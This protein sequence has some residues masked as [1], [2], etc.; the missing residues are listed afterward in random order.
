MAGLKDYIQTREKDGVDMKKLRSIW[1]FDLIILLVLISLFGLMMVYSS[2]FTFSILEYGNA[3]HFFNKQLTWIL[4]G[5]VLFMIASFFP[6]KLY[7]KYVAYMVFISII[8]LLL[9]LIPGV[10]VE[11]NFATRW[12]KLGPLLFQPSEIAKLVMIVYFAKV[13]TNKRD[14][15]HDFRHGLMP[16]LIMLGIVFILI[17][18][19]PDLGTALSL[20]VACGAILL[21]SGARW[22]HLTGLLTIAMSGVLILAL[23][24][25]YRMD[26]IISFTNP[27]AD[28]AGEGF[29]LINSYIAISSGGF[30]GVGLGNSVQKLGY[31]P[32]AHTDFIMAIIVEELGVFGVIAVMG[33]YV[34]LLLKGFS[35][36]KKTPDYFAKLL[37]FGLIILISFQAVLN[38]ASVSGMMPI[39]GIPLPFISYGGTSILVMFI[40]MGILNNISMHANN[41][42]LK[43]ER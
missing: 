30:T 39:T 35:I 11:R 28:P 20:I 12:L 31:L 6:Y 15:I 18:Q 24:V 41:Y 29:Q 38:L 36:F 21:I 14:K 43:K 13:Y 32:E 17:T 23:T 33:F 34:L 1:D 26:R 27:F 25:D 19:Q 4:V 10:G 22:Y 3:T 8:L 7:G 16:P 42:H 40:S 9:V 2:S 37:T 5:F